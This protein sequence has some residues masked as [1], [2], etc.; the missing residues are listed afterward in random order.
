[1]VQSIERYLK[2]AVVDKSPAIASAVLTSAYKLMDVCPDI[3]KRW[4]NEVQ[5]AASGSRIMVQYHALG[6]LYLIRQ[7]DRLAVT[8]MIQ[9]FTRSTLRSP[10]AYCLMVSYNSLSHFCR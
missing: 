5:E 3:I 4:T 8:K 10:Y 1:M 6:L 2:Q 9:K 7:S